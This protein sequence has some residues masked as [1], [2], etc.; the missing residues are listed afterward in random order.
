MKIIIHSDRPNK[1]K[2]QWDQFQ[3]LIRSHLPDMELEALE[4]NGHLYE[5]LGHPLHQVTVLISIVTNPDEIDH[6]LS[7]KPLLDNIK[8][9]LV[10]P[11]RSLGIMKSALRLTPT[12]IT[13]YDSNAMDIISV[14]HKIYQN[15]KGRS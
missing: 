1:I 9:I 14:L 6:L 10:L 11:P 13:Y 15:Q 7:L 8:T 2:D 12:F 5:K 4:S 3:N